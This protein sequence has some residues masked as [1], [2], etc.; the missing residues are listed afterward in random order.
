SRQS[1]NWND[2]NTW[3]VDTGGGFVNATA[4]QT[5]TSADDTIEIQSTHTVTVTASVD[6]DQ[7]TVDSGGTISVNN[8]VTF[9]IADGTGTDL[10]DNGTVATAGTITN[11]GQT[12][13]NG[14]LQIDEGGFPG[15]TGAYAY[16]SS[17]GKLVFN[18]SSSSYGVNN[19]NYW[20]T[21]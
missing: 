21:S 7:L 10:T 2:F 17:T 20:P 16:N 9:T 12:Q 14:T 1:G 19:D 4:G 11:S 8:G 6:A 18:N 3:Q 5:P 13:V 15:G